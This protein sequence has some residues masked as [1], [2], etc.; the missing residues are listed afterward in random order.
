MFANVPDFLLFYRVHGAQVSAVHG[1]LQRE[2]ANSV[3]RRALQRLGMEP[4]PA[5][6]ALHCD[7]ASDIDMES[8]GRIKATRRWLGKIEGTAKRRGE[9]AIATEC[10]QRSRQLNRR[11][12]R[13]NQLLLADT[14]GKLGTM[15]RKRI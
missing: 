9:P 13:Y 2:V 14:A 4:S 12:R 6:T 1:D 11:L 5:E 7:Y 3:R 15:L 8:A 10:A